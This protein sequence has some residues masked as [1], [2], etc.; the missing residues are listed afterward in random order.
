MGGSSRSR[1]KLIELD[2]YEADGSV[3]IKT[4]DL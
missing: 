4:A 3:L 1:K 2:D